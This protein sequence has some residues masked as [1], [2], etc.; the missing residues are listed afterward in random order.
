MDPLLAISFKSFSSIWYWIITGVAWSMACHWTIGV[1]YDALVRA[2]SKGGAAADDA[3]TLALL[4]IRRIVGFFTKGAAIVVAIIA[5]LLA[6][7]GTFGFIYGYELAQALFMLLFPLTI[8]Q[9]F[10]VRLAF[11]IYRQG[12]EGE[13]LRKRLVGRRFWN[14]VIG[15]MSIFLASMVAF[16]Q[17]APD[18]VFWFSGW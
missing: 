1:P 15:L 4:N 12:I 17:F 3:E 9:V 13:A 2:H 16:L 6:I 5:F 7:C 10:N 18:L 11:N 8:V 14:Q